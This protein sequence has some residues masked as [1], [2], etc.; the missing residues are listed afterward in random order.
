MKS[1]CR[2]A[3]PANPI[4]HQR[5]SCN[6]I[7]GKNALRIVCL[8]CGKLDLSTEDGRVRCTN[9]HFTLT[10]KRYDKLIDDGRQIVLFGIKYRLEYEMQITTNGNI[11]RKHAFHEPTIIEAAVAIIVSGVV[12]NAAYDL[13]K[14]VLVS[15]YTQLKRQRFSAQGSQLDGSTHEQDIDFLQSMISDDP[16]YAQKFADYSNDYIHNHR[17]PIRAVELACE[18]ERVFSQYADILKN[19]PPTYVFSSQTGRCFHRKSCNA[20]SPPKRR[21]RLKT[22]LLTP[23]LPCRRCKPL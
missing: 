13:T 3:N 22:A 20:I 18:E 17:S 14:T 8:Q 9:C 6:C 5:S 23:L 7:N 1:S 19:D 12:G 11:F 4:G 16:E 21:I 2:T 15:L 10:R